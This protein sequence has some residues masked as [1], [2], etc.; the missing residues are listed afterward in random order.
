MSYL[1]KRTNYLVTTAYP[2]AG[3]FNSNVISP[4]DW[5]VVSDDIEQ[6]A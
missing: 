5:D 3:E 1:E 2:E 4:A 6:P